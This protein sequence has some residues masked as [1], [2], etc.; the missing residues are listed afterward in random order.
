MDVQTETVNNADSIEKELPTL[1]L[2]KKENLEPSSNLSL[3]DSNSILNVNKPAFQTPKELQ[4][5]VYRTPSPVMKT[6]V[7]PFMSRS[8]Q[9]LATQTLSNNKDTHR[10]LDDIVNDMTEAMYLLC[11]YPCDILT[12]QRLGQ[13]GSHGSCS[14]RPYPKAANNPEYVKI[15]FT[16][17][18]EV[19]M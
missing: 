19:A 5:F 8:V 2:K 12:G 13:F 4:K 18:T 14:S 6:K 15:N 7:S 10:V 9:N 1:V 3:T 11:W 17:T 16:A